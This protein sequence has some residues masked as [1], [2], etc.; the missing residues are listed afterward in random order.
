MRR[1]G[2]LLGMGRGVSI[3]KVL[4]P[5]DWGDLQWELVI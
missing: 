1:S 3:I 2:M 5:D 4:L